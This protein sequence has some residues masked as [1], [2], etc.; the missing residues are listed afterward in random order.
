MPS[1]CSAAFWAPFESCLG[2][3]GGQLPA[4]WHICK[5]LLRWHRRCWAFRHFKQG[6]DLRSALSTTAGGQAD[7]QMELQC[8]WL[9]HG[10][11]LF[12]DVLKGAHFLHTNDIVH[13]DISS[14]VSELGFQ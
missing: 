8:H 2:L 12:L 14:Q 4:A 11:A 3:P 5:L 7:G 1:Q 6:G 13:G 9:R 10:K